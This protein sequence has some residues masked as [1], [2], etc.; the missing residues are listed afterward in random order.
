MKNI[1]I[2]D[3]I[4]NEEGF[5][6]LPYPDPLTGKG[7]FTFGHGLTYITNKESRMIVELRKKEIMSLLHNRYTWFKGLSILRKMVVT[8]MCY[9]LGFPR[10][11]KFINTIK[12]ISLHDYNNASIEMLDSLWYRQMHKLDM[13]DGKNEENRAEW[14]AWIMKHNKYRDRKV[15]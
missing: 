7:P 5:S 14:L 9:Q 8:N 3:I 1:N 11:T 6:S 10:F 15:S 2:V 4:C 12:F 13:L